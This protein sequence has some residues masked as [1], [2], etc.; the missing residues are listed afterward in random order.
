MTTSATARG[1][2]EPGEKFSRL[3][4]KRREL[5]EHDVRL[6]I[7]FCGIC[8][9]DIHFLHN[10]VRLAQARYPLVP[11][12][13]IAGTVAAVGNAVSGLTVGDRVGVGCMVDSCG[14]CQA[15]RADMENYCEADF[16]RTYNWPL[17]DGSHTLGG[18]SD[19]VVVTEKFALRIPDAIPLDQ[20]APLLCAGIT[21]YSP[22]AHWGAA[23]GK[24]VAII[25]LGGL[26]HIGVQMSR[27]FGAHTTVFDLDPGKRPDALRFGADEFI[28]PRSP[29]ALDG[30]KSSFDLIISTVPT[31][32]DLDSFVAML[33]VDGVFVNLGGAEKPLS[34]STYLLRHNR[35]SVAS[36]MIG[37]IAETQAMLDFCAE[38]G[39]A[40]EVEVVNADEIDAAFDRVVAGD[41]RYRFVIDGTTFAS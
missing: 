24:R 17:A 38:H 3:D 29:G 34:V 5:G 40:A 26:G 4:V 32:P 22:L 18:F 21:L 19:S 35:R 1:I 9:S 27:A 37:G 14:E 30:L 39:I 10:P 8:H 16:T 15:C 41:V 6:D 33:G 13:E 2:A 31:N 11:G 12:H 23:P 20:A 36:S 25:G 28:D 7:A